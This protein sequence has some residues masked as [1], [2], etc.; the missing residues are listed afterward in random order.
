MLHRPQFIPPCA[1]FWDDAA[2]TIIKNELSGMAV[3]DQTDFSSLRVV[4]PTALHAEMLREAMAAQLAHSF[5]P[6]RISTLDA[7]L[8]LLPPAASSAEGGRVIALY[9]ELKKQA[10]LK[11][12]LGV[13]RNADL[14][15][16]A[17]TLIHLCDELTQALLPSLKLSPHDVGRRW[18]AALSQLSPAARS[19]LS[20]ESQLV[21]NVWKAQLDANDRCAARHAQMM[22][23]AESADE[24]LI[25]I[26]PVEASPFEKAFLD[27]YGK[28]QPVL[29]ILLDWHTHMLDRAYAAA[30]PEIVEQPAID[31]ADVPLHP[32]AGVSIC[33]AKSFEQQAQLAAQTIVEWL[34]NGRSQIAIVAQDRVAARRLRA[35]LE[36]AEIFVAD[37]TGWKLSTTR[38]AGMLIAWFDTVVS[39]AETVSLLDLLKSPYI[40]AGMEKRAD[41]I[42]NIEIALRRANVNGGWDAAM[43]A[44]G[45]YPDEQ[46]WLGALSDAARTFQGGAR[47]IS[48][49]IDATFLALDALDA[50]N[51]LAEDP[52][53]AQMLAMLN[54]MRDACRPLQE[55]LSF[56]EWRAFAG[57]EMEAA[58]FIAP[59]DDR[60][61]VMLPLNGARLRSFDAVLVIG[62][63]AGNLPSRQSET[64][65]FANAVRRE[66]GLPTRESLQRQQLRDFAELLQANGEVV[67][68]WQSLKNGEENPASPWIDRLRF[69]LRRAEAADLPSH[70]VDIRM[71]PLVAQP[72]QAPRPSAPQ[73]LPAR[74]S[75][76]GYNS[77][78]GCP[79]QFFA[80]HML[81]LSR[82]EEL[83]DMPEKRDYGEWLHEILNEYHETL[84]RQPLPPEQRL[85]KLRE[86]SE[87]RF[88]SELAGS[89]AALGYYVRWQ[90]AMQAYLAWCEEH[91]R[92]G[93]RYAQGEQKAEKKIAFPG[94]EVTLH[95]RLDRIDENTDGELALFDYKAK[96][97]PAL[98]ARLKEAEDHQLAFYGLLFDRPVAKAAYVSLEM[99]NG[100][101]GAAAAPNYGEWRQALSAQVVN[102]L[103]AISEGAPLQANGVNAVC[104][105]CDVRGLCR[106][107]TW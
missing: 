74:L 70:P 57:L 44:L 71:H 51:A 45:R 18:Q 11:K 64:L 53:G 26:S 93:W 24:P 9:A 95:G 69:A 87:K 85:G 41:R 77:L 8:S 28:R 22:R 107:G 78:T 66:L 6:P 46:A 52:A 101:T 60:R 68:C 98:R 30:W 59:L 23:L 62:A 75:A 84:L 13:R 17:Y 34:Q 43:S 97:L 80:R 29:P 90:K 73:L 63:D 61:V 91:E 31:S 48:Q 72:A 25:W 76:S 16:L 14:L 58:P 7:W 94:G 36:R 82:L 105:Y 67:V 2:R 12:L 83:S 32:P 5:I 39:R 56:A 49:W 20:N 99:D 35:L 10:W 50:H 88:D 55:K 3:Q 96:R 89:A 54:A 103:R 47:T 79:Y 4:V 40:A 106:K 102:N 27:E 15:P 65:F 21:W 37:E 92:E 19:V 104:E 33:E 86:I 38:A 42:M 1:A 81:G 100:K